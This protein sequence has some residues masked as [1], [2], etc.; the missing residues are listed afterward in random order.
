MQIGRGR[1]GIMIA[2]YAAGCCIAALTLVAP[3]LWR[4][5]FKIELDAA[6]LTSFDA[7]IRIVLWPSAVALMAAAFL[8]PPI[9]AF[10]LLPSMILIYWGE[11]RSVRSGVFYALSG[12]LTALAAVTLFNLLLG[13]R[14]LEGIGSFLFPGLSGGLAY[15]WV[16]GK[17]A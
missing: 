17:N 7:A 4:S 12:T 8:L 2:G 3:V 1:I 11:T 13:S 16:A 15:W 6:T 14:D 5:L 9:A 10:S